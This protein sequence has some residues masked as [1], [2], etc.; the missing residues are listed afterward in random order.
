MSDIVERLRYLRGNSTH[1][2]FMVYSQA[3]DEIT[4][5]RTALSEAE[6]RARREALEE[7]ANAVDNIPCIGPCYAHYDAMSA[8]IRA[9]IPSEP[10]NADGWAFAQG[11]YVCKKSGSWWAGRVVGTYATE[12]TPRGYAVQLDKP[13]GPV[14]IYPESALERFIPSEPHD[15]EGRE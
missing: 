11:D 14:Q 15:A 5:L 6:Q 2:A 4:R 13:F 8:A 1:P 9:L 10:L 12:Q 7:A 3:A